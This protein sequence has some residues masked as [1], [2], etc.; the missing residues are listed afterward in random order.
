MTYD[1][2]NPGDK[3]LETK[4]FGNCVWTVRE[5]GDKKVLYCPKDNI[6]MAMHL[7][8]DRYILV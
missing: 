1:E 2:L 8:D 5:L 4:A 7:T 6:M 3:V